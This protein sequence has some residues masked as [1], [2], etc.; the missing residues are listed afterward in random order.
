MTKIFRHQ[1]RFVVALYRASTAEQVQ[2]GL[3]LEAQQ[4]TVRRR[5]RIGV[6]R[7][8]ARLDRVARKAH[9]LSLGDGHSKGGHLLFGLCHTGSPA[10]G[11]LPMK[12]RARLQV[13]RATRHDRDVSPTL[14]L[15][16]FHGRK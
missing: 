1:P 5:R 3:D 2:S 7:V 11:K 15:P 13:A 16:A 12:T 6:V 14:L 10:E 8:A 4:A 9:T